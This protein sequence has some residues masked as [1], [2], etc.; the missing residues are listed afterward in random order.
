MTYGICYGRD[1]KGLSPPTLFPVEITFLKLDMETVCF[2]LLFV[3]MITEMN[4]VGV[5]Y[6]KEK[7][8]RIKS[9]PVPV[10]LLRS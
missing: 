8:I 2:L 10:L 6:W 9:I 3:G 4:R 1:V 7:N 5:E